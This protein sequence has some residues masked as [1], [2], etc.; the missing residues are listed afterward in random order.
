MTRYRAISYL[1]RLLPCE[2]IADL[3]DDDEMLRM[4]LAALCP[5]FEYPDH[6]LRTVGEFLR[7]YGRN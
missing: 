3:Y 2:R 5:D 1:G 6:S 4:A 7:L